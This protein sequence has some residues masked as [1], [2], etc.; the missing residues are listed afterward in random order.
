MNRYIQDIYEL[1]P[2]CNKA[3]FANYGELY[4]FIF[5]KLNEIDLTSNEYD[6]AIYIWLLG[7]YKNTKGLEKLEEIYLQS[8][9]EKQYFINTLVT[10]AL[11]KIGQVTD[12]ILI[13]ITEEPNGEE[14]YYLIRNKLLL[15]KC[16]SNIDTQKEII[17]RYDGISD[18][19]VRMFLEW[20]STLKV[21]NILDIVEDMPQAIKEKYP[22][23]PITNEYLSL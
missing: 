14:D 5:G 16:F 10:E 12:E 2:Y 21:K 7:E 9:N 1:F 20:I 11:L 6:Y 13:K 4:D 18:E 3:V 23:Y 15:I 17:E 22:D 19:R 8:Y